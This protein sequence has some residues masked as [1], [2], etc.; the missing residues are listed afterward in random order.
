MALQTGIRFERAAATRAALI[1]AARKL[2][3]RKGYYGT[4]TPDVAVAAG[5]TRGAL[6]HHFRG[7]EELFEAVFRQIAGE[8]RDAAGE[9]VLNLAC[10]PW[11]QLQE[12]LQAFLGA[13]QANLD[14]QRIVLVD[15]PAVFG[16]SKWREIQSEFT[17]VHLV[18]SLEGLMAQ[19]VI[20]SQPARPLAHLI[21][22]ALND[23]AMSIA[24][25]THP[26]AAREEVGAALSSLTFG[27][28]NP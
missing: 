15:G 14:V 20:R 26:A 12:G 27:L 24:N 16:W 28:R 18:N 3:A 8:V 21:L 9:S 2:F 5:V 11:R 25:S 17:L 4:G 19:R 6:Y 23:A 7:K 22:A 10:D 13:V 1:D